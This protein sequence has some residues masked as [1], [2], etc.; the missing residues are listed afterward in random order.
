[1]LNTI[2]EDIIEWNMRPEKVM[3]ETESE[4]EVF[5]V[6]AFRF[7]SVI[8]NLLEFLNLTDSFSFLILNPTSS[9][10]KNQIYGYR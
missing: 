4:F 9:L 6:D 8:E 1:M 7:S 3:V 2:L 10:N 5:Y